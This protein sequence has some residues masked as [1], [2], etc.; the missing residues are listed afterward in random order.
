MLIYNVT[1]NILWQLHEEWMLWLTDIYLPAA[2]AT[3]AFEKYQLVKLLEVEDAEG[4]TYA[5]Q[6]YMISKA[7]YNRYIE[8]HHR[9][10]KQL[11]TQR[12]GDAMLSFST[13]MEVVN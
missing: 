2:M 11:E 8:L 7:Q 9:A 5:I 3:G 1:I 6:F 4:P 10:I 13:L 12:W